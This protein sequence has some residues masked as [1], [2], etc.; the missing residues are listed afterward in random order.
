MNTENHGFRPF[1]WCFLAVDC[2]EAITVDEMILCSTSSSSALPRTITIFYSHAT[3]VSRRALISSLSSNPRRQDA[4]PTENAATD[5]RQSTP[6]VRGS[7]FVTSICSM[8]KSS[9]SWDPALES[10]LES[11]C[12]SRGLTPL[13]AMNVIIFLENLE[14]G[15]QFFKFTKTQLGIKHLPNTYNVII[16]SLGRAGIFEAAMRMLED[17]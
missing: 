16:V 15:F 6:G 11:I 8:F 17:M 7:N 1:R 5:L 12:S 13:Q 10:T 9:N 3:T 14:L 4:K 2:S